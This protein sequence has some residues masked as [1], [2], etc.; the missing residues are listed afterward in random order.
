MEGQMSAIDNDDIFKRVRK[1]LSRMM[2]LKES[3]ITLESHLRDDLG[4]DSVDIWEII[5][6]MEEEFGIHIDENDAREV[7]TV[8]HI[9]SLVKDK[10]RTAKR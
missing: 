7:G 1:I 3:A 9:V 6:K 5:T 2:K 10:T 4:V 8:Q